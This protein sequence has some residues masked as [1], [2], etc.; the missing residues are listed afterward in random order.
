MA[1]FI[2]ELKVDYNNWKVKTPDGWMGFCGIGKTILEDVWE[3]ETV[4][5]K[6]LYAADSHYVSTTTGFK[7]VSLMSNNDYISTEDGWEKI[8]NV[9]KLNKKEHM[10]D[11]LDV[12]GSVY[13]TNKI[14]SHNS[15]TV[16]AYAL[17]YACFNDGK[18]IGIVSDKADSAKEI[19]YRIKSYYETL[20]SFLKPGVLEWN[21]NSVSFENGTRIQ[22][23]ATT[24]NSFRRKK[25]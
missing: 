11:L 18:Y 7:Q 22:V 16:G 4:K 25:H 5:G 15:T 6:K 9:K 19:L 14:L 23:A 17:W 8:K 3:L 2:E 13:Y 12:N 21:K 24:A 10:Y 20:P 1:N